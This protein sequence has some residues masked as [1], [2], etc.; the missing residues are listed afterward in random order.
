[1]TKSQEDASASD[2]IEKKKNQ[3]KMQNTGTAVC[4]TDEERAG[5]KKKKKGRVELVLQRTSLRN[6]KAVRE[7]EKPSAA[8]LEKKRRDR[9]RKKNSGRKRIQCDTNL[10]EERAE[11]LPEKE[12]E[13][14]RKKGT[15]VR[16]DISNRERKQLRGD[17]SRGGLL[18][19]EWKER[20]V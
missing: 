4:L 9:G 17:F 1:L 18:R 11:K 13:A 2:R 8:R 5:G 6:G 14:R 12:E 15:S 20:S 3:N 10:K 7:G 19:D 16:R